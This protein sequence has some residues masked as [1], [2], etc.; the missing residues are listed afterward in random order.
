MTVPPDPP[1]GGPHGPEDA[2]SPP[3]EGDEPG[4][5]AVTSSA[6]AVPTALFLAAVAA[7][8]QVTTDAVVLV[9]AS[10]LIPAVLASA[11]S[12]RLQQARDVPLRVR[13]LAAWIGAAGFGA[14]AAVRTLERAGVLEVGWSSVASGSV[15][16]L[17]GLTALPVE[18]GATVRALLFG[19]RRDGTQRSTRRMRMFAVAI[20]VVAGVSLVGAA[21]GLATF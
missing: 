11:P 4:G 6:M 18:R 10:F 7:G 16:L 8:G 2:G 20:V 1:T 13:V 21:T 5:V 3:P 17:A 15:L 19:G 14:S 9:V 12:R